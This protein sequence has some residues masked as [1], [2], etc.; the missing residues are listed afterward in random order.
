[1]HNIPKHTINRKKPMRC[2]VQCN[3]R[4]QVLSFNWFEM[5]F[6]ECC[7]SVVYCNTWFYSKYCVFADFEWFSLCTMNALMVPSTSAYQLLQYSAIG[8][9]KFCALAMYQMLFLPCQNAAGCG[10]CSK[11]SL[12]LYDRVQLRMHSC[13]MQSHAW[14]LATAPGRV[15]HA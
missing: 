3:T 9:F 13:N 7:I 14:Q 10:T 6:F 11:W 4:F 1:M 5:Y 12:S 15:V 2:K 8:G